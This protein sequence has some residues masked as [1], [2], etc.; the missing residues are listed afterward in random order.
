MKHLSYDK[1]ELKPNDYVYQLKL[2]APSNT[3]S[4]VK[5]KVTSLSQSSTTIDVLSVEN[6]V[7]YVIESSQCAINIEP[8]IDTWISAYQQRLDSLL[9]LKNN[10]VDNPIMLAVVDTINEKEVQI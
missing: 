9:E 10:L 8:I 1:C 3:I 6:P 5:Y 2:D 4:I 7:Q